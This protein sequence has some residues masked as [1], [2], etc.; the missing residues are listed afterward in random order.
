MTE[1]TQVKGKCDWDGGAYSPVI[2]TL[3]T[4]EG[5]RIQRN[6]RRR[7]KGERDGG[8]REIM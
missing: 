8:E 7:V 5:G 6:L 2:K 4:D 3:K 1:L